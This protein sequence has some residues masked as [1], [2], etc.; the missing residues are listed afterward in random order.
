MTITQSPRV[1]GTGLDESSWSHPATM[2]RKVRELAY[3]CHQA[4]K[5]GALCNDARPQAESGEVD[6]DIRD[7]RDQVVRLQEK[8]HRQR[9]GVLVAWDD[10]LRR[11]VENR[12]DEPRKGGA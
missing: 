11:Q 8:I 1:C 6:L 10:A 12:L 5:T 9:L 3:R 2:S 7:L 4:L